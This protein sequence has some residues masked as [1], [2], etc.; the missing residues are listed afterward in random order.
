LYWGE[1][2]CKSSTTAAAVLLVLVEERGGCA[3]ASLAGT[4]AGE[5]RHGG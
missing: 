2:S 3:R 4:D 5:T 1:Q